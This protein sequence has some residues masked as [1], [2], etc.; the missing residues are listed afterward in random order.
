MEVHHFNPETKSKQ[1]KH[2]DS[3]SPKKTCVQPSVGKVM[4]GPKWC[5]AYGFPS[6]RYHSNQVLSSI[7]AEIT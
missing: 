1:C 5:G 6:Q 7:D 3:P 2:D 4:L